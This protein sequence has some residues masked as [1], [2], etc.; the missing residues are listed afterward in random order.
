[1]GRLNVLKNNFTGGEV[2]PRIAAR[3]GLQPFENGCTSIEN[4]LVRK[5]G[6]L[7]KRP[8]FRFIAPAK[9]PDRHCRLINFRFSRTQAYIIEAGHQYFRFYTAGA[10][11][12]TSGAPYEVASPYTEAD[13]AVMTWTQSGDLLYLLHPTHPPRSLARIGHANWVLSVV[14]FSPPMTYEAGHRP[15]ATL[16]LSDPTGT[17]TAT[18]IGGMWFLAADVDRLIEAQGG[19]GTITAVIDANHV[20]LQV[21]RAFPATSFAAG[22]WT[23]VGSPNTSVTP[24]K[25]APVGAAVTLTF[26][27]LAVRPDDVGK[28]V[29]LSGG[30]VEITGYTSGTVLTGIIR[31]QLSTTD[32]VGSGG[33]KLRSASWTTERG[34]PACGGFHQQRFGFGGVPAD[35]S[36]VFLSR[37][38]DFY[39]FI[40]GTDDDNAVEYPLLD[41][42]SHSIRFVKS[43]G[44]AMAVGTDAAVWVVKSGINDPTITPTAIAASNERPSGAATGMLARRIGGSLVYVHRSQKSLRALQ[45][46]YSSDS[47]VVQDLNVMSEHMFGSKIQ[48]WTFTEERDPTLW[49]ARGDGQIAGC[50]WYPEHEVMAW[51][52]HKTAGAIENTAVIPGDPDDELWVTVRRTIG[53]ETVRYV[54]KLDPVADD[55]APVSDCFHV[56]S[57]LTYSGDPATVISGLTHLE[58]E[59]VQVVA[60]GMVLPGRMVESGAIRLT[61]P[62]AKVHVGLGYEASF[63]PT[64]PDVGAPDGSA[65]GRRKRIIHAVLDGMNATQCWIGPDRDHLLL[66]DGVTT[67][68]LD[69]QSDT[70]TRQVQTIPD[71]AYDDEYRFMVVHTLPAPFQVRAIVMQMESAQG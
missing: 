18:V 26:G 13:V 1:M 8:G 65:A 62:A 53:G 11:I 28:F 37:S 20:T 60:D 66:L 15:T 44:D 2:S 67:R 21:N 16:T 36:R 56:D 9:Y 5:E 17:V 24:S 6:G 32:A 25:K 55:F 22:S 70:F 54:E 48:D 52:R 47:Y 42:D 58:G 68:R 38:S 12:Q 46:N 64:M 19:Q 29:D 57:G 30:F 3:Y 35:A 45:Y 23:V 27:A 71:T 41:D 34:Y 7:A 31:E 50:T 63:A 61:Y 14:P 4:M 51:N 40:L 33:W 39:S 10:Q 59:T 69:Q 43:F 49:A